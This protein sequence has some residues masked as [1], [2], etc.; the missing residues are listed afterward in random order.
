[1]KLTKAIS[2]TCGNLSVT[3]SMIFDD[4]VSATKHNKYFI[5]NGAD[6]LFHTV[7]HWIRFLI[8]ILFLPFLF[9]YGVYW[10]SKKRGEHE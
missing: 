5:K 6:A 1:M 9:V 8:Y 7:L 4:A 2:K 10:Q 3:N